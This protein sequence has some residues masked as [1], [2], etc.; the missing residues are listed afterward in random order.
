MLLSVYCYHLAD[1]IE[2]IRDAYL[3]W[4]SKAY[5][6]ETHDN[7]ISEDVG[8][9]RTWANGRQP[10]LSLSIFNSTYISFVYTHCSL[11]DKIYTLN[12][13]TPGILVNEN[14]LVQA[15]NSGCTVF[16]KSPYPIM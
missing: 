4:L 7:N 12:A 15:L 13:W 3:K 10:V 1:L 8:T 16:V 2:L 9:K 14:E 6:G 11:T 5:T